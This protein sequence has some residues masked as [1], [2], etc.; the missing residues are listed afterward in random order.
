MRQAVQALTIRLRWSKGTLG[1][2]RLVED[3]LNWLD[4]F[5]TCGHKL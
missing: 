4:I 3:V 2:N 5:E 1:R